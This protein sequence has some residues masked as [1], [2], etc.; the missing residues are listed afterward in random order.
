MTLP[1]NHLLITAP[2]RLAVI[3]AA[4]SLTALATLGGGCMRRT[5]D[6]TSEPAGALVWLND[7]EVGRTP[8]E[9]NFKFYGT[10]D[11]RLVADG[12]ESL[13]TSAKA[14]APF[15]EY[16]GPDLVASAFPIHNRVAWHFKLK[17]LPT[18]TGAGEAALIERGRAMAVSSKPAESEVNPAN[19]K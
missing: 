2:A 1:M 16:P 14:D 18:D 13:M 7:T 4:L 15:V 6:I 11:V 5:I 9:V 12:Y 10:Y 17:A 3:A 8:L 19:K